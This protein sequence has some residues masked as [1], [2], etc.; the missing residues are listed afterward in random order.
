MNPYEYHN[1]QLCVQARFLFSGESADAESLQLIGERG[2]QLRIEK[3][4]IKR[5]RMRGPNTP[6]LVSWI[7]LP[8][9]WQ[10][11]LIE[12]FGAPAKKV[13]QSDFEKYYRRDLEASEYFMTYQLEDGKFLPDAVIDEYTIN[14]SVLNTLEKVYST[15]K[16]T[17]RNLRGTPTKLYNQITGVT[18][19]VWEIA[20]NNCNRFKD[21]EAH[22]LP[23]NAAALRKKLNDY[24][25][26][27]YLELIHGNWCNKSALKVDN[28][29]NESVLTKLLD[30]PRNLDNEQ[31]RMLYN[32]VAEKMDWDTIS[33]STVANWR[34]KK[35]LI[36]TPGRR[37]VT[38]FMNT[39]AMQVKRS[40][41]TAP[42]Y[43]WS[44]DGWDAELLYQQTTVDKDG[45][46]V[47]TYHN[48]LTIVVILD[49]C[50]NY[51]IGYAIGSHETPELIKAAIRNAIS[52]TAELFGD[53]Y[54]A[55]QLQS[56]HYSIKALTP[57]YEAVSVK[58]TPA[59]VKNA[60]AKPIEPYFGRINKKYCQLMPNWSGFGITSKKD[61]QP[62]VEYLNKYRHQFPDRVGCADQISRIIT[63]ERNDKRSK[64]LELWAN[65]PA[66]NKLELSLENY[67]YWFGSEV[68]RPNSLE[69][70][71]V[72]KSIN[73]EKHYFDCF[74]P[75]FR[76]HASVKWTLKLDPDMPK[77]ALAVSEDGKL[78]FMLQENYVQPMALRDRKDGDSEELQKVRDFNKNL[79][80]D[81]IDQK[82]EID[83]TVDALFS[84]NPQLND[85]LTKLILVD[86]RGQH[87]NVRNESRAIATGA[88]K[89]MAKQEKKTEKR[90]L[91]QWEKDQEEYL[92]DKIMLDKYL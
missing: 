50:C 20:A 40:K 47:T 37:G 10:R 58:V 51:P 46:N 30:D 55:H 4:N 5:T 60:K 77:H 13:T 88:V 1:D 66:E 45:N 90:V 72:T 19:D 83:N 33:S 81:I 61:N 17:V 48:R 28:A 7:T 89:L 70:S 86:S 69:G 38:E 24:K 11:M 21:I 32:M 35:D 92:D 6:M 42:L 43:F 9:A 27:G 41:P 91:Q 85:T 75:R 36:T 15:R 65:T 3:G 76:E 16:A 73:G 56:D 84:E 29:T 26:N 39:K 59:R 74:D 34:K 53:R 2:L 79:I 14:A 87:K 22:T 64:Y 71:G 8:P 44:M 54:R 67:L 82:T 80:N 57:F 78:R 31:I 23:M 18:T 49:P 62:N 12:K 68:G 25:K 63:L 52:H